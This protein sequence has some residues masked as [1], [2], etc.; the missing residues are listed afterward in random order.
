MVQMWNTGE[1]KFR[2]NFKTRLSLF[3]ALIG[4][5]GENFSS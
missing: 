3:D 2:K 5:Q 1:R 4:G